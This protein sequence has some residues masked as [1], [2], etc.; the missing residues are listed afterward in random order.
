M[1]LA[2]EHGEMFSLCLGSRLMIPSWLDVNNF[3]ASGYLWHFLTSNKPLD[4]HCGINWIHWMVSSDLPHN[5]L[6]CHPRS[7]IGDG[8]LCQRLQKRFTTC[9]YKKKKKRLIDDDAKRIFRELKRL[10]N[11]LRLDRETCSHEMNWL[12]GCA[13][14]ICGRQSFCLSKIRPSRK[15]TSVKNVKVFL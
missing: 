14:G 4:G 2:R 1:C 15:E 12:P 7:S 9:R 5:C 6:N 3:M 13:F 8:P 11:S 10:T